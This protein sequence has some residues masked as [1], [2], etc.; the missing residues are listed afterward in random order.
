MS[1]L[2]A[3]VLYLQMLEGVADRADRIGNRVIAS[4]WPFVGS[5]YRGLLVVG[6]ALAGWD[7][8]KAPA[9]WTP[10]RVAAT[11]GRRAVLAATKEWARASAEPM[12]EPLRTRSGS[13][14]WT[15]SRRFVPALEPDGRAPWFGRYA[16]WNLFPLGWGDTN[17]SPDGALWMA[18]VAH[19]PDLFWEIVDH[20]DPSRIV[21]LAGKTYWDQMAEPLGLRDLDSLKWPL[22]AGGRLDGRSIVWTYHPGARLGGVSRDAFG[23]LI[24]DSVRRFNIDG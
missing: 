23:S 6:Q 7:D 13:P 11:E 15:L 19:V 14:F 4:H 21:V 1:E 10:S 9:L 18:Q 3:D 16:W 12:T 8:P 22:I 2:G 5:D 20:L 24:V 17:K